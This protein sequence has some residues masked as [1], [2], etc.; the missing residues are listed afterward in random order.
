VTVTPEAVTLTPKG[1][2]YADTVAGV[3]AWR[4]VQARDAGKVLKTGRL[5][6]PAASVLYD[7][8]NSDFDPMG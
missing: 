8:N 5:P 1:M 7:A 6:R 2:F 3:L 4:E